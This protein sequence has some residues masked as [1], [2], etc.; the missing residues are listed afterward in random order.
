MADEKYSPL[1]I[2]ALLLAVIMWA[3]SFPLLKLALNYMPPVTLAAVRYSIA[4]SILVLLIFAKFGMVKSLQELRGDWK[5]L[6]FLGLVGVALP[7]ATLNI[8]L[9]FTTASVSSIIQACGPVFTVALAVIFLKERLGGAKIAGTILAIFGTLL[10]ISQGGVDLDNSTFVGNLFVL[11]SAMFYSISGVVTKKALERHHPLTITGWNIAIGSLFLCL[12]SPIEFGQTVAFPPDMIVILLI[13]AVFPGC[14]AF[15]FYNY[16]L[17][18]KELSSISFF[19]YLIP[20]FSTIISM[21][22]LG[23]VITAETVLFASLVI[24]G[25]ALAQYGRATLRRI[26]GR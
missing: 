4:G 8:G 24:A 3:S 1:A 18:K 25:V 13:L 16:V 2:T 21:A 20:V 23:E 17:Q 9:Q 6:T 10:L 12:F 22:V 14:L 26:R 5:I 19:V 7:N 15:L 11:L